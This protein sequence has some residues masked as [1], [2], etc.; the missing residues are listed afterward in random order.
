MLEPSCT[1][2]RSDESGEALPLKMLD[3]SQDRCERKFE[4]HRGVAH[5]V[6]VT[7]L[8]VTRGL[9]L[10]VT[11]MMATN[12]CLAKYVSFARLGLRDATQEC[13]PEPKCELSPLK[14]T[15]RLL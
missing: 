4:T 3:R 1:A 15:D 11:T 14:P 8:G 10:Y 13:Q 2:T 9:Q 5:E 12:V 6:H 7:D